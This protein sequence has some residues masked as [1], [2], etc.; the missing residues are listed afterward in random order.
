MCRNNMNYLFFS[1]L[2]TF[3][4]FNNE[5]HYSCTLLPIELT[6]VL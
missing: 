2:F 5:T 3:N 4:S 1:D 6:F